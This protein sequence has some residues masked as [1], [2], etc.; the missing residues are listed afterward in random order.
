MQF[1]IP[2]NKNLQAMIQIQ[3][4]MLEAGAMN[5]SISTEVIEKQIFEA[6]N[7]KQYILA[8]HLIGHN[9]YN[10]LNGMMNI[11]DLSEMI[12]TMILLDT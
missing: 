4:G 10:T 8:R 6:C 9:I 5:K 3:F 2:L 12:L 1:R 11:L 7:A